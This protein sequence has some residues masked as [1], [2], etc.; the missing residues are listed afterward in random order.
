MSAPST[1]PECRPGG[2]ANAS[3]MS[4]LGSSKCQACGTA[5]PKPKRGQRACSPR[6]R[7]RLWAAQHRRSEAREQEA[8]RVARDAEVR[9]L[10]EAALRKLG[11]GSP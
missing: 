3:P 11:E 5:I 10:L 9:A 4:V 6:C 7:W 2:V 8:A 1:A